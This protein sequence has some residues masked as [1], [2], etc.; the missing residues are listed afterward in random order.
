MNAQSPQV[1]QGITVHDIVFKHPVE[2]INYLAT[3]F[4]SY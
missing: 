1:S 3:Y 2:L 4:Q